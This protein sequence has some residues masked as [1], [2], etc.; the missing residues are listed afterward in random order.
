MTTASD[1][2]L[3]AL[4]KSGVLGVGQ[5]AQAEDASDA[6]ADLNDMLAQ[7]Q[8]QRWLVY[9]LVD[10]SVVSTGAQSYTVCAGGNINVARP[11]R[12]EA[13]YFRQLT[14]ANPS[15][16]DYPV[17]IL[18]SREDYSL[19]RLKT[20][21]SFQRYIFYDAAYPNGVIYPWP[22]PQA[23]IYEIHILL[24]EQLQSFANTATAVNMPP[25][26]VAAMKWNLAVRLRESYQL[27]PRPSLD[28]LAINAL[29]VIRNAN[30]Q[31]PMLQVPTEL[32]RGG[33]YNIF[34]DSVQ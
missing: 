5:Q 13:A 12:L 32:T 23:N 3:Q 18:E 1:I 10:L 6:L 15:Q 2:L 20:L 7:W 27:P 9:H 26:Y 4:K 24:K 31:I 14:P 28:K 33:I 30:T 29:D 19:I 11:D 17:R 34:S 22:V 8:R 16:V 21:Q 25:E